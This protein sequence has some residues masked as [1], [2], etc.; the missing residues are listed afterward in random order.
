MFSFEVDFCF[1]LLATNEM[2]VANSS[3][4]TNT[5]YKCVL[6]GLLNQTKASFSAYKE[7]YAIKTIVS[8]SI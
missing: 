4:K 3:I 7:S 8:Q 6:C 5:I 2:E 1:I